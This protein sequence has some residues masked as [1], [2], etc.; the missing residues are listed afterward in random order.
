MGSIVQTPD[1]VLA[2]LGIDPD[3]AT[4][5]ERALVEMGIV[6]AEGA[7]KRY[8]RYDP[9]EKV[10]VQYYPRSDFRQEHRDLYWEV[11]QTTAYVREIAQAVSDVLQLD[12]IPIRAILNLWV[13]YDGRNGTQ[14]FAAEHLKV[15]GQDYWANYDSEDSD[16]EKVCQDGQIHSHG[17]WPDT[18]GCVKVQYRAGY[19]AREFAGQGYILDASPI[20]AAI[21][22]EAARRAKQAF[23]EAKKEGTGF[24][25]GQIQSERLGDYSYSIGANQGS[26]SVVQTF[27]GG[28]NDLLPQTRTG[29]V[30]FVHWGIAD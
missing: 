12:H 23:L 26:N 19:T 9:V 11:N 10:R 18:P 16:G 30:D 24:V 17:A 27:F 21:T 3:D 5:M 2:T 4:D 6:H 14:S 8:L 28:Q 25:A 22:M 1:Y 29:L 20:V 15:E 7:I 13:N